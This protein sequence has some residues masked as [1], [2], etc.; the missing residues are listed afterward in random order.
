MESQA[1]FKTKK[2]SVGGWPV[3]IGEIDACVV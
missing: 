1:L 2:K 3:Q